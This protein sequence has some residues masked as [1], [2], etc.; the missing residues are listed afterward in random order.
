MFSNGTEFGCF[1]EAFC[2]RCASCKLDE[3]GMPASD[4]CRLEDVLTLGIKPTDE[5][6][7]ALVADGRQS[8]YVCLRFITRDAALRESF[9]DIVRGMN[10]TPEQQQMFYKNNPDEQ[11]F[12]QEKFL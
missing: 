1:R 6:A 2:E 3:D 9:C 12:K 8:R 4:S 10:L 5:D 7:A 11:H